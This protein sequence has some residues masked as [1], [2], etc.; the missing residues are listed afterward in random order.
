MIEREVVLPE[1]LV[2]ELIG[3]VGSLTGKMNA[4]FNDL[5]SKRDDLRKAMIAKNLIHPHR[6][7]ENAT[8]DLLGLSIDGSSAVEID[9]AAS[10]GISCV[11][12]VGPDQRYSAFRSNMFVLPHLVNIDG[13]AQGFMMMQELMMAV[14]TAKELPDSV[15]FIDGSKITFII[16][17]NQFYTA[18]R[19]E[20]KKRRLDNWRLPNNTSDAADILKRFEDHDW[21]A[22][23]ICLPNIVGLVK[24]VTTDVFVSEFLPEFEDRFDDKLIAALVL[25]PGER[26]RGVALRNP[27]A[28][29]KL[30]AERAAG[31]ASSVLDHDVP[32]YH[33]S[34][35]YPHYQVFQN[36]SKLMTHPS[37]EYRVSHNYFCAP[38][39]NAAYKV[40][41]SKSLD[42]AT[43]AKVFEWLTEQSC[44]V[45]MLEPYPMYVAD[46]FVKEAVS[47]SK[48][49][50][51][52]IMRSTMSSDWAF[53]LTGSF[54]S[55]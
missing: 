29:R 30:A 19:D 16:K 45:D 25:E 37:S 20:N 54:R 41:V 12:R 28:E 55:T 8:T 2:A 53:S 1:S 11:A 34:D 35:Y 52:E 50:I 15:V 40:E 46:Q 23:F 10:Y 18:F 31:R 43:F 6:V 39:N 27:E 44:A 36:I 5:S 17:I 38:A 49:A 22:D 33:L 26:T 48:R 51:S 42:D 21:F 32:P 3:K 13:L 4:T 14:G 47:V 9:R 24:L 7:P